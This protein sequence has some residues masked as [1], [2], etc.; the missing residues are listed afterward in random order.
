MSPE[1]PL[2][3]VIWT[4]LTARQAHLA[5]A[6]GEARRFVPEISVL[7]ALAQPDAKAYADLAQLCSLGDR[8][9][10]WD[11]QLYTPQPGWEVVAAA[12]LFQMVL[13][14][15]PM[16]EPAQSALIQPLSVND[17]PD[18]LAL[19]RLTKPGPFSQRTHE[20]GDYLGIRVSGQ[21]V[22]MC[23][24]RLRVPGYAEMSAI[25]THPDHTGKGHARLLMNE[26]AHRMTARGDTPFLH[27]RE[28]NVR[29]IAVY[30]TFGFKVRTG[31]NFVVLR[32]V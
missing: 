22:A 30:Q 24:G 26:V 31:F 4:A 20:L 16:T 7:A 25:C 17:V 10:L 32:R 15:S 3:R 1:H 11:K 5:E 19:T 12:P 21:L 8:I 13:E 27:V 29:A 23:G 14:A 9:S 18:M 6:A 28:D 2:D